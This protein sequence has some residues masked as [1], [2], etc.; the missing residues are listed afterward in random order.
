MS[1]INENQEHPLNYLVKARE[2]Q[3]SCLPDNSCSLISSIDLFRNSKLLLESH[4]WKSDCDKIVPVLRK[5]RKIY[6]SPSYV[7]AGEQIISMGKS[8]LNLDIRLTEQDPWT[9]VEGMKRIVFN[10]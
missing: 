4:L 10:K 5:F 6:E 7:E 8:I 9:I 2:L 1:V 3:L